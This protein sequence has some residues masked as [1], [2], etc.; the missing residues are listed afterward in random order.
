MGVDPRAATV[1]PATLA[2]MI[3]N[4]PAI[5]PVRALSFDPHGSAA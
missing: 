3:M 4:F 1:A 5:D 2:C